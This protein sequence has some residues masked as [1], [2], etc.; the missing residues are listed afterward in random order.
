MLI[1]DEQRIMHEAAIDTNDF[2]PLQYPAE[3]MMSS[4]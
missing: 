2:F 1:D 3:S 4:H